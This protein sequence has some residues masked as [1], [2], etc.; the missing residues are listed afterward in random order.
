MKDF[1]NLAFKNLRH[2]GI[3]SWLT[4][5]GIFIG[6]MAVV[7]LISLGAG[8]KTAIGAQFGI[9]STE[10]ITVQAGG[11]SA[12]G[13][14]GTGVT[15]KL[16]QGD[17]DAISKLSSVE[18]AISRLIS[19][20]KVEF[21]DVVEFEGVVSIP[22]GKDRKLSYDMM[23]V[24]PVTGRMLK[25]GDSNKVVLGWNFY[26][27][28][29]IFGEKIVPGKSIMIQEERF[30]VIG[31]LGK[32]GSF[33]FDNAIL[34]NEDAFADLFDYGD[35]V[36]L[37]GVKVKDKDLMERT[38][39]DIEK[40]MRDRRDV[41]KG[42]EDFEVSTPEAMLATVNS[43]LGGVQAFVVIIALISI[44]V[45]AVGIVNTMTTSV[46]ERKKEI[47]IMKAVGAKNS[48][49]FMQF[50]IE[51]GLLGLLG[52]LVGVVF[53]VGIGMLGVLGINN[54]IGSE[55]ALSIDFVLIG[56]AL[57]GSFVV[58]AVSGVAPALKAAH[59]NPVEALRG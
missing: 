44:L 45:G 15:N 35:D 40:L 11:I 54:W 9:S 18:T 21:N 50:L 33:I 46:L 57:V 2:R 53:G 30:L 51:S 34:M 56:G 37:I 6:V 27:D 47:G 39:E 49:V 8:L 24:E 25:D 4:L 5:L 32:K 3:R 14:P 55:T 48:Q 20:G 38:K 31:I 41:E 26:K 29:K 13:P 1:F 58:G 23:E 36:D 12:A 28:D 42:R 16:T 17:K 10:I 43:V 22:E 19:I 59:Q 7:S 52:G